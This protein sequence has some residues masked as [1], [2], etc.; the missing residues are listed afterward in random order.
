MNFVAYV[1]DECM[2]FWGCELSGFGSYGTEYAVTYKGRTMDLTIRG[3]HEDNLTSYIDA[4]IV[5]CRAAIE[6]DEAAGKA[7][8]EQ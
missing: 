8:C 5:R 1:N 3:I 7:E 2:A 6:R 4:D